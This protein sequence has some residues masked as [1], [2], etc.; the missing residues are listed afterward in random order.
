MIRRMPAA[1]KSVLPTRPR[2]PAATAK[3]KDSAARVLRQFRVVFN[4][5]KGHFRQVEKQA[6]LAG[7]QLWALSVISQGPGIGVNDLAAVMDVHQSTASNLLRS[8]VQRKLVQ[9][10][11]NGSD[12][13]M[14]QLYPT[15]AGL[16]LLRK[17]P[18]PFA[19]LLPTALAGL[20]PRTLARL[21][22]DL[23][24]LIA[25]LDADEDTGSIPLGQP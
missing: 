8:L 4:A 21:E 19:G 9:V 18:G 22:K 13:R 2:A 10:K 6:G 15:A 20:D 25:C 11:R 1:K 5:V 16:A 17:A 3:H 23:G 12:K 7:A 24:R 14:V